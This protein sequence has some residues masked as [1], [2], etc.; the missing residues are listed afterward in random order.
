MRVIET[1]EDLVSLSGLI[2]AMSSGQGSITNNMTGS[3]EVYLGRDLAQGQ[4]QRGHGMPRDSGSP[5]V[6]S[7]TGGLYLPD[8]SGREE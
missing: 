1:L 7:A 6:E 2:G 3:R 8:W 5:S 4:P